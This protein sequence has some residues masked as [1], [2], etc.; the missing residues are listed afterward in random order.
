MGSGGGRSHNEGDKTMAEHGD[1][2]MMTDLVVF[3][4]ACDPLMEEGFVVY[5]FDELGN[6]VCG[7]GKAMTGHGVS[8]FECLPHG[9]NCPDCVEAAGRP[10]VEGG[11]IVLDADQLKALTDMRQLKVMVADAIEQRAD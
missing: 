5:G 9:T 3:C 8:Y 10:L 7:C 11:S 1:I 6:F 2:V 4:T